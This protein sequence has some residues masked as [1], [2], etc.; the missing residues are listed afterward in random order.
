MNQEYQALARETQPI[1][2]DLDQAVFDEIIDQLLA[3]VVSQMGRSGGEGSK[4]LPI[5]KAVIG[6]TEDMEDPAAPVA[7]GRFEPQ[8]G[9]LFES[10]KL[11][12]KFQTASRQNCC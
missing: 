2:H 11:V 4:Q 8:F 9:G 6:L 1:V 7:I 12:F 3:V 10:R 5:R